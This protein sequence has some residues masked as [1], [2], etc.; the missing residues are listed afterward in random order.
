MKAFLLIALSCG[1]VVC[2]AAT[3][4]G[5]EIGEPAPEWTGLAGVDGRQHSIKDLAEFQVIV[6]C[7]TCNTCPYSIDYESRLNALQKKYH[8]AS[9]SVKL[10]AINSNG[11]AADNLENMKKRAQEQ[12][13]R[14]DYLRDETQEV[15]RNFGAIYTPEFYVLNQDRRVIYKGAMDDNTDATKVSERYVEA[16]V[17]AALAGRLPTVTKAGARGCAIRFRR[18]RS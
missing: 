16:A 11:I 9:A 10:V 14:F 4:H 15:A 12:S 18:S 8:D 3:E 6:I 7:F 13:F 17:D 1:M 2:A 5:P